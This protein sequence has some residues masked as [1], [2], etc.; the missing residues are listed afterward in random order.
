MNPEEPVRD[1]MRRTMFNLRLIDDQATKNG[2]YEVTQ[3]VNSFLGAL[4]HPWEL[5]K[6]ELES[7]TLSDAINQGWP[8]IVK[9]RTTDCNPKNLGDLLRF[10][11]NGIAH[12]NLVFLPDADNEI[13]AI[14]LWN[15]DRKINRRTWGTILTIDVMRQLLDRFVELAEQLHQRQRN[16]GEQIA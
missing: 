7:I 15:F 14:Q 2:P 11:R 10:M 13:H 8:E 1:V 3:L 12:G 16:P 5:F 6:K 4:A 9:E